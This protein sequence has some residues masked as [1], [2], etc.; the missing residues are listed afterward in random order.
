MNTLMRDKVINL[1]VTAEEKA[2]IA[3]NAGSVGVAAYLRQL[4]LKGGASTGPGTGVDTPAAEER[5]QAAPASS[6]AGIPAKTWGARV[7]QLVMQGVPR[8]AAEKIA[9]QEIRVG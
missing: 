4:G 8:M 1:R 6:H 2:A 5:G 7:R 9:D 3:E